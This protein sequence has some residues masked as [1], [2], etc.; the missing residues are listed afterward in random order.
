MPSD[1]F[2]FQQ[3]RKEDFTEL[4]IPRKGETKL[5]EIVHYGK[6]QAQTKFLILG[7]EENI[8]PQS[9]MGLSGSEKAFKAFLYRFLNMQANRYLHGDEICILGSIQQKNP[10]LTQEEGRRQVEALDKLVSE[11]LLTN[12]NDRVIPIVIGGGHNN[13][14]PLIQYAENY[15]KKFIQAVNL[16]P[17]ADC[18]PIEGRH[19]GNSFSYAFEADLM[20][21]YS[22]IG[23]HKAYNSE[24]LLDYLDQKNCFYRFFED[25]ID[26]PERFDYDLQELY[27][28]LSKEYPVGIELD[29]DSIQHM[30]SSA[31]TPSGVTLEQAR[32]YLRHMA[33]HPS[34]SY[35]HLPEAAPRTTEDEKIVG[36]ALAYLVW[37]FIHVRQHIH[38]GS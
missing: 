38:Q 20:H 32:K 27:G 1:P 5:G 23:L 8:G 4:I 12:C 2:L 33:K 11:I 16:D 10:F 35:L 18:R 31:Y 30:P 13:A 17:H 36:K 22:V 7:I 26:C 14:L 25:Y 15:Y 9:N 28:S 24:H 3:H 21:S 29:M 19:S 37:D 6:T 34:T